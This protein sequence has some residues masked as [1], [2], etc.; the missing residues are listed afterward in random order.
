MSIVPNAG[1]FPGIAG[2]VLVGTVTGDILYSSP[3]SAS[4][5]APVADALLGSFE[6]VWQALPEVLA[7]AGQHRFDLMV[8][9]ATEGQHEEA[10]LFWDSGLSAGALCGA[11]SRKLLKL[12][13]QV[14]G[15]TSQRA[16]QPEPSPG[17]EVFEVL[18]FDP[19]QFPPA[20]VVNHGE[21]V[22]AT[23]DQVRT[24]VWQGVRA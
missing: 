16:P 8:R 20:I 17:V 10:V 1:S 13:M 23:L 24:D 3:Y 5:G 22:L 18:D 6:L 9:Q 14:Y 7:S 19:A 11:V 12:R 15:G 21:R 4:D 2:A